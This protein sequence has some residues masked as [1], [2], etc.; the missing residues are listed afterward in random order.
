VND[1]SAVGL[2]IEWLSTAGMEKLTLRFSRPAA[3]AAPGV[4]E[5]EVERFEQ[6]GWGMELREQMPCRGSGGLSVLRIEG[7]T[8]GLAVDRWNRSE[9]AVGKWPIAPGDLIV[10][11]EPEVGHAQVLARLRAVRRTRITLLRW[12]S[13][14]APED[15]E[16][17]VLEGGEGPSRAVGFKVVLERSAAAERLGV[18][19]D[20]STRDP[21]RTV[22]TQVLAGGLIDR[23]NKGVV[24]AQAADGGAEEDTSLPVVRPGDELESV[25]GERDPSYFPECCRERRVV[26]QLRRR[27]P[28]PSAASPP[29]QQPPAAVSQPSAAAVPSQEEPRPAQRPGLQAC[30]ACG[31]KASPAEAKAEIDAGAKAK[32]KLEARSEAK[33]QSK[34]EADSCTGRD[35]ADDEV[36]AAPRATAAPLSPAEVVAKFARADA[37]A[38][39]QAP[40]PA[41]APALEP[42]AAPAPAPDPAPAVAPV[43]APAPAAA[44]SAAPDRGGVPAPA[45]GPA[46]SQEPPAAPSAAPA[47]P[48]LA[49]V[50]VASPAAAAAPASPAH[51]EVAK[52]NFLLKAEVEQLRCRL[53][54]DAAAEELR[55]LRAERDALRAENEGFRA[56]SARLQRSSTAWRRSAEEA[57]ALRKQIAELKAQERQL[58]ERLREGSELEDAN[59]RLRSESEV[60]RSRLADVE[61]SNRQRSQQLDDGV[62]R[63]QELSMSLENVLANDDSSQPPASASGS[64]TGNVPTGFIC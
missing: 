36:S 55:A 58:R 12:H 4:W 19:L 17:A 3:H 63:L 62:A 31:P 10:A 30:T 26:L 60:L 45:A 22:V 1:S 23:H 9:A 27:A 51:A 53:R 33:A 15:P 61:E 49:A 21:T 8:P 50:E 64:G 16:D 43:A 34:A 13:G 6:E 24:A 48:A 54:S 20:P 56:E 59:T 40:A 29:T 57:D 5:A 46:A 39:A 41:H 28:A 14:P 52:E 44:P 7:I 2:M 38:A 42:V 32:A 35:F 18:Q 47:T 11:S 37:A 25:N